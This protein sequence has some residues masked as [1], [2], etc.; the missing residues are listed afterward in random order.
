[1]F[2]FPQSCF[3]SCRYPLHLCCS[4]CRIATI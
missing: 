4:D 3:Q 2:L 1:M